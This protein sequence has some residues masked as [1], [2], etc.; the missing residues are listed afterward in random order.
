[1]I[2]EDVQSRPDVRGIALDAVGISQLRYPVS[3][4]ARERG[5]Q[6][7]VAGFS[8]TVDLPDAVKGTHLS[9]FVHLV[10]EYAG[11]LSV[12]SIVQMVQDLKE[13]LGSTNARIDT[14]FPFFVER[15]APVS[16]AKSL[17]ECQV[18]LG[19][20]TQGPHAYAVVGVTVPVTSVCPCSKAISDYGA[21]NQRGHITIDVR[22]DQGD[23]RASVE[24]SAE[25]LIELAERCASS[26]VYPILKRPD[27]RFVT[28][29][30]HDNPVFVEDMAR[31]AAHSLAGDARISAFSVTATNDE[32][33]HNHAA[34]ARVE[35][36]EPGA[37]TRIPAGNAQ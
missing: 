23:E 25:D 22:L 35:W 19:A 5:K 16:G 21:H 15:A 3:V 31:N 13:R 10:H 26:P 36:P 1:M 4:V 29:A 17:L 18:R 33:I 27:E 6:E 2:L 14:E 9:R 24:V 12:P 37:M 30:A 8:L 20:T 32:S 11:D 7:T 28:M 34:F